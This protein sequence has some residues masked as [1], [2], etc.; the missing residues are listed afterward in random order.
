MQPLI[1][2][3]PAFI[4][5]MQ[6]LIRSTLAFIRSIQSLI[7]WQTLRRPR[8]TSRRGCGRVGEAFSRNI[9]RCNRQHQTRI[10]YNNTYGLLLLFHE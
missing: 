10:F 6:S 1:P 3:K 7:R 8:G 4:R 9:N 5:S 2:S